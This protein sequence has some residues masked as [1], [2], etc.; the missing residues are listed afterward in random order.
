M[1]FPVGLL[2]DCIMESKRKESKIGGATVINFRL[3][4]VLTQKLFLI[5]E[6]LGMRAPL[7]AHCESTKIYDWMT[8]DFLRF[9]LLKRLE[10]G[11]KY[12]CTNIP[13]IIAVIVYL[14]N[15]K[16]IEVD[17]NF[18]D[19][20]DSRDGSILQ[21]P[22][23]HK[24]TDVRTSLIVYFTV[25]TVPPRRSIELHQ[26]ILWLIYYDFPFQSPNKGPGKKAPGSKMIM[27]VDKWLN[28]VDIDQI[29]KNVLHS[30]SKDKKKGKPAI[31][32]LDEGFLPNDVHKRLMLE[33][34]REIPSFPRL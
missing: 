34:P 10:G 15:E 22:N 33:N 8:C 2:A 23:V 11:T 4:C 32:E 18:L 16:K 3:R 14:I 7:P 1:F 24:N 30:D 21:K 31:V 5:F 6:L 17:G 27:Q 28:D 26:L 12:T 19:L 29:M 20:F 13:V 9:P 25:N